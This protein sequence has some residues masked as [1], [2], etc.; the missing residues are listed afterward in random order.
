MILISQ[1]NGCVSLDLEKNSLHNL[2]T[3]TSASDG[4]WG[5]RGSVSILVVFSSHPNYILTLNRQMRAAVIIARWRQGAAAISFSFWVFFLENTVCSHRKSNEYFPSS[6]LLDFFPKLYPWF[7]CFPE[8]K[9]FN[10][11]KASCDSLGMNRL[12][13][14]LYNHAAR[15]I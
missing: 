6:Y 1:G 7:P 10:W 12:L 15:K 4:T 3:S 11:P 14:F 8:M 2:W 5:G 9:K 13:I